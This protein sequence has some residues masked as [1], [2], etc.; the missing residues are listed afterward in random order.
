MCELLPR[1]PWRLLVLLSVFCALAMVLL[2]GRPR[3]VP[4]AEL[5]QLLFPHS[6][7][8]LRPRAVV[9]RRPQDP[10]AHLELGRVLSGHGFF[11]AALR[12]YRTTL[13]LGKR[14][15]EVYQ[16]LGQVYERL[17][18]RNEAV[19]SYRLA[20]RLEPRNLQRYVDLGRTLCRTGDAAGAIAILHSVPGTLRDAVRPEERV[21]YWRFRA[22]I[23]SELGDWD[24]CRAAARRVLQLLP[25][26]PQSLEVEAQALLSREAPDRVVTLLRPVL[27]RLD[28]LD[29]AGQ[30]R[31]QSGAG[32]P[33]ARL[34]Y[35]LAAALFE[36]P[37]TRD[38]AD[39]TA[40]LLRALQ[41]DPA[42][43]WAHYAL[44]RV[45]VARKQWREA[46][47]RFIQARA[48]GVESP[49]LLRRAADVHAQLGDPG[50]SLLLRGI[51]YENLGQETR[52]L[53]SFG[54][55]QSQPGYEETGALQTAR[56]HRKRRR[57]AAA[58]VALQDLLAR[59]PG[60]TQA[61]RSMAEIYGDQE[62]F[63]NRLATLRKLQKLDPANADYAYRELGAWYFHVQRPEESER[64][65]ERA[66]KLRPGNSAYHFALA[67]ACLQQ[68][69][70]KRK[71]E[72]GILALRRALTLDPHHAPAYR[73][74]GVTLQSAGQTSEA[75][76][77]L[78]RCIDLQPGMGDAYSPLIQAYRKTGRREEAQEITRLFRRYQ[79]FQAE[80]AELE[81][82]VLT[83]AKDRQAKVDLA[84]FFL[85]AGDYAK[86]VEQLKQAL[87]LRWED[88]AVHETLAA[89]YT[90]MGMPFEADLARRTA[91]RLLRQ[92]PGAAVAQQ[93]GARALP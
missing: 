56:M 28:P 93:P 66:L 84:G 41:L 63:K 39:V 4:A 90:Q 35:L 83:R 10:D 52:A 87:H 37:E 19:E 92:K 68:S 1:R 21:T 69:S 74:L 43:G 12:E 75:V 67:R 62:D 30:P 76:L 13:R 91:G 89:C 9:A 77:A 26:D 58:L 64:F 32:P 57:H 65:F 40:H 79:Q 82:R 50:G 6:P 70:R 33:L 54:Q 22:A 61:Y 14:T 45:Y 73:L 36:A 18:R 24:G 20:L 81:R 72:K 34:H 31:G 42:L 59:E 25:A 3:P 85:H 53:E 55:L 27:S 2:Q 80:Q 88:P 49:D 15:A 86:A 60:A 78:E 7:A 44:G 8:A 71:V 29:E 51:Y 47:D 17:A 5:E 38:N 16:A 23:H 46:A 11:M 48:L